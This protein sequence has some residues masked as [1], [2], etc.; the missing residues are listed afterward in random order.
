MGQEQFLEWLLVER[1]EI[2]LPSQVVNVKRRNTT[3]TSDRS[4]G[5]MTLL[6][7]RRSRSPCLRAS[8]IAH[9][10]PADRSVLGAP[11]PI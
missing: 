10:R 3:Y 11:T 2:V 5:R 8:M 1:M 9:R 6:Q 7:S 4:F